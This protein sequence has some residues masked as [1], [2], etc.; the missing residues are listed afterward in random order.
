MLP[1]T[2]C[3]R[4]SLNPKKLRDVIIVS[5]K[6]DK[7]SLK[8]TGEEIKQ[9]KM[10]SQVQLDYLEAQCILSKE[11]CSESLQ[12]K[13]IQYLSCC[14][15][16]QPD[17]SESL[18]LLYKVAMYLRVQRLGQAA[19]AYNIDE[20]ESMKS[21]Q[22]H[23]L[24]EELMIWANR[25]VAK[26]IYDN[27]KT[28]GTVLLRQPSPDEQELKKSDGNIVQYSV[29]MSKRL[30][31]E[32]LKQTPPLLVPNSTF[33]ELQN[34]YYSGNMLK[35]Q[36]LLTSDRLYPQLAVAISHLAKASKKS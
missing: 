21:W 1:A 26:Y 31:S 14:S 9:G 12:K 22:A 18:H 5:T 29:A 20:E 8:F 2:V 36:C 17:L 34:A 19:Y 16:G 13:L 15:L 35:F 6:V 33:L 4:L 23:L 11:S 27:S 7:D 3:Q 24:V 10:E 25:T 32:S 30:I 28:S